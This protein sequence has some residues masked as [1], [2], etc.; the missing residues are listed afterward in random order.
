MKTNDQALAAFTAHIT[1]ASVLA[2]KIV[3]ALDDHLGLD[4]DGINWGH[5]GD[6]QRI[7]EVLKEAHRVAC[8]RDGLPEKR[9]GV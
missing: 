7:L 5:V 9:K 1:E 6:A 3:D 4:A 8:E 2:R